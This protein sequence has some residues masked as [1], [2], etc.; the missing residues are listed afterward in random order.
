MHVSR[1][2]NKRFCVTWYTDTHTHVHVI[3]SSCEIVLYYAY[4]SCT[5]ALHKAVV[6]DDNDDDDDDDN[7]VALSQIERD[8]CT[9]FGRF[10]RWRIIVLCKRFERITMK[11]ALNIIFRFILRG[12]KKIENSVIISFW[13]DYFRNSYE[14]FTLYTSNWFVWIFCIL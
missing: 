2:C 10:V 12:K 13:P 8:R 11:N 7:T 14:R 4:V 3:L 1:T 5:A 6:N 9:S